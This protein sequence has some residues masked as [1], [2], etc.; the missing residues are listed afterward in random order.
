MASDRP[1]GATPL[2]PDESEG[3]LPDHVTTRGE[4]DELE[5]ANIQIGVQ[6]GLNAAVLRRRRADVLTEEFLYELHRRMFGEVWDWAGEIRRTSKNLGVDWS[7]I[8]IE[9]RNLIED[10]R[11]WR[12]DEVHPP[13]D[14]ATRFHHRLVSIHPFPNGN[15][16]HARL[17]ADLIVQQAGRSPFTWGGATL[18]TTSALRS[19]YIDALGSADLGDLGPLIDFA[20]S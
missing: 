5:E 6:W 1:F 12:E 8:R 11:L 15:G 20:R 3:L 2:D 7:L 4:L 9:V 14:L 18:A 17:M 16:R 10:A 13:D 19:A